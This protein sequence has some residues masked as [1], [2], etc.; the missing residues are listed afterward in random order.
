MQASRQLR[1]DRR[2]VEAG[3]TDG[4]GA[5]GS[6]RLDLAGRQCLEDPSALGAEVHGCRREQAPAA[7]S[8]HVFA[9]MRASALGTTASWAKEIVVMRIG[10]SSSAPGAGVWR[11][12]CGW[13]ARCWPP[14]RAGLWAS[15]AMACQMTV[16]V[17]PSTIPVGSGGATATATIAPAPPRS[18]PGPSTSPGRDW[19][20]SEE[21]PSGG[22]VRTR[23]F[24]GSGTGLQAASTVHRSRELLDGFDDDLATTP[25]II[26]EV[27]HLVGARGRSRP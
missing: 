20:A 24:G 22:G 25:L 4:A 9:G 1:S 3:L 23:D 18:R 16:Q 2:R 6:D 12:R 21:A 15:G 11:L 8:S 10:G 27:D 14:R 17:S 26:A 5:F 19:A 7:L 13:P